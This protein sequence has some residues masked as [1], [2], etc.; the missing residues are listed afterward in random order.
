[1]FGDRRAL[2]RL[3][4]RQG[5]DRTCEHRPV[6]QVLVVVGGL[7]ATGK[8][9][10]ATVVARRTK[11]PYLRVDRI[12]QTIVA[13]SALTHPL[14][15]VGYAVAYELARG[16]LRLGLDVIAE[17][18][19]P[20]ALTR[21][22]WLDIAAGSGAAIVEVEVICSDEVEHRRRVATRTSD[23][24]GLLK[25]TWSEIMDREYEPWSR[26]HLPLDSARIS[27]EDAAK[28]IAA[29][30]VSAREQ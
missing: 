18:V 30:M 26:P 12:E 4:A 14:G 24:E 15:P 28:L 5:R 21:D 13:W 20:I 8:S 17:C 27:V 1:M 9:T 25:P 29:R 10:I 3:R 6:Q 23:V 11:A 19:N 7:P 16:Q 2:R 22:A